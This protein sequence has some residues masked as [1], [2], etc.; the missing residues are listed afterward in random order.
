VSDG[1]SRAPGRSQRP[2][3]VDVAIA[4]PIREGLVLVARR[5]EGTHLGGTW[6]FPGGKMRAG[7]EAADAAR[8]ELLEETGLEALELDP[9]V[10]FV[11]DYPDRAVCLHCFVAREPLGEVEVTGR[12]WAW[13]R[14]DELNTAAMPAANASILR[15]LDWREL[16]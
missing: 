13:V 3:F 5:A 4:I 12:E 16:R 9:L 7:E 6:E 14:R 1:P 15:A 11:H 8:R 10:V 2:A